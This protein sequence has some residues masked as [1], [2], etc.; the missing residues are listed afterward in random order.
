M[1]RLVTMTTF[2][3]VVDHSSFTAAA[4]ELGISRALVSRH[5]SDLEEHFGVR[6]LN[7]TTR[8]VTPSEAGLR[9]Y[10]VCKRVLAQLREGENEIIAI[11][12]NVEGNISIVCPKW[13]GNFDMSDAAVD[14]CRAYPDV[15]IQLHIGEISLNPHEFLNRGFDVCI[16]PRR[17]RDSDIIVK[18][19]GGIE[20]VLVAAPE[21]LAERG[22]PAEAADLAT[23][24]CLTKLGET[25]WTFDDGS[26]VALKQPSRFSSNS[27][28]TLCTGAVRGLG[29]A[30]LP[31]RV[32][33]HDLAQGT[34][35]QLLPSIG[36]EDAPLYAAYA[37]GGNVP[38]KV[39]ELIAFLGTWFRNRANAA[40]RSGGTIQIY[41][42][43]RHKTAP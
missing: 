21:Y 19:I 14:F 39:R 18:K 23:H 28:F 15:S 37:P 8:S 12:D 40:D 41:H 2:M 34:L 24:D 22:E 25:H 35:R 3:K 10:D 17:V 29:I 5:I 1:D 20:Y 6:L 31:R 42:D 33:E 26:R 36:L 38:K 9:Y 32:A 7:R 13:V 27:Y 43:A 30:M 16:Q 11:K 4:D